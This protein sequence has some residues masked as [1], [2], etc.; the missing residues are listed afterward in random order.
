MSSLQKIG[1][2]GLGFFCFQ[3]SDD[4]PHCEL[5]GPLVTHRSAE[6]KGNCRFSFFKKEGTG[7]QLQKHWVIFALTFI[8]T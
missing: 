4:I 2:K 6:S 1:A 3:G 5:V 8:E 7:G